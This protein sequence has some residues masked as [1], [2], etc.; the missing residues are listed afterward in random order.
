MII[1]YEEFTPEYIK[2]RILDNTD[3][4][5][6]TIEGSFAH[7]MASGV[8][9]NIADGSVPVLQGVTLSEIDS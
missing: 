9:Y 4:E 5:I 2:R 6:S 8:A 1:L 3:T 7:D